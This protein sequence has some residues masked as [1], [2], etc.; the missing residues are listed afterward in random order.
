[1]QLDI[2]TLFPRM[3]DGPF[4]ESIVKRARERNL[5]QLRVIN[6]RDFSQDKHRS[7]DDYPFGGGAGMVLQVDPIARA[8]RSLKGEGDVRVILTS[9]QGRCFNQ[10]LAWELAQEEHLIIICGHYEGVDERVRE[11]LVTDEIS[12]G[13]FVLT[14]GEIPALLMADAIIRLLPGALGAERGAV[15][16]SFSG[17]GLLEYPQYTRPEVWEGRQVPPV[18]LSGNHEEIRL[19]RRREALAR[20][21]ERRP[22]LLAQAKLTEEDFMLLAEI[23]R[24]RE[25]ETGS[26]GCCKASTVV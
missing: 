17:S 23:E 9:P 7:V 1:M 2:L 18:L 20:T 22:D 24:E 10:Q 21:L 26:R 6:I 12:V 13:D 19:W 8:V 25:R 5:V 14:G 4:D 11:A 15:D 3:F 16:D